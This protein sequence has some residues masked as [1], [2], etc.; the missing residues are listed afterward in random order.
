MFL[1]REDYCESCC[2]FD[3]SAYTGEPDTNPCAVN[4]PVQDIIQ[5]LDDLNNCGRELEGQGYLEQWL[6]KAVEVGDW[7]A[8]LSVANE[9]LGQY[10]RSMNKSRGL[11]CI[12]YVM[13]L[14]REHGM[15]YTVSAATVMLNAATTMKCFGEAAKSIPVFAHVCRVYSN[16]L[17]PLDYRF[18]GLYNNMAL[19]YDNIADYEQAEK[20]FKQALSIIQH[21]IN[22]GNDMAVTYCNMAETYNKQDP[23]DPRV[24]ECMET[25]WELLN[26]PSLPKD[27]YHAF[28]ISK[29]APTFG[30]FGYFLY[31]KE[32]KER[33]AKIYAGN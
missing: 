4:L 32:L 1:D 15:G 8:Q 7:R 21:T 19:S 17:D 12:D 22:P 28:T 31:A 13:E 29:C 6:R 14:I 20:Y 30:Y 5:G 23:E 33:A 16:K 2:P 3:A 10:R 27:G 11:A 26:D 24:N 18:A 25:A 9:L